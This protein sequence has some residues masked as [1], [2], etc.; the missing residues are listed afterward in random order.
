MIS[1]QWSVVRK[2]IYGTIVRQRGL[3][4]CKTGSEK[5]GTEGQ[6]TTGTD[7]HGRGGALPAAFLT[8]VICGRSKADMAMAAPRAVAS[9]RKAGLV[10]KADPQKTAT[11]RRDLAGLVIVTSEYRASV[12][13]VSQ[14]TPLPPPSVVY[15]QSSF[16]GLNHAVCCKRLMTLDLFA[17]YS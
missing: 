2:I 6:G 4:L 10:P 9:T 14:G 5:T 3:I 8:S 1:D 15:K 12:N 17:D 7:G 11:R 13:T 16:N